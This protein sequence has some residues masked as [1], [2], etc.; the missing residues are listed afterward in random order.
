MSV[1]ES[2]CNHDWKNDPMFED[3]T[4][5]IITSIYGD[6]MRQFC[7]KCHNVRFVPKKGSQSHDNGMLK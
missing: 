2:E 4:V 6:E 7:S 1:I 5:M 3:E